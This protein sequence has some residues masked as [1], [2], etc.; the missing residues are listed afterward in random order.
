MAEIEDI[1]EEEKKERDRIFRDVKRRREE[2]EKLLKEKGPD[3]SK[4]E[5]QELIAQMNGSRKRIF[6]TKD[7]GFNWGGFIPKNVHQIS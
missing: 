2:A 6:L 5:R 3:L 4:E 1:F 7:S